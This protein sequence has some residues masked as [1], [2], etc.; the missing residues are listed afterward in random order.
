MRRIRGRSKTSLESMKKRSTSV[1][2]PSRAKETA[3]TKNDKKGNK[4]VK[5]KNAGGD[6][7]DNVDGENIQRGTRRTLSSKIR[8]LGITS[9][10]LELLMSAGLM[11]KEK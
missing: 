10:Q 9:E 7:K 11:I 5:G 2:R 3:L 8:E 6:E 4:G 1:G